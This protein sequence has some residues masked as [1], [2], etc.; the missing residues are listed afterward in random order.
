MQKMI[1]QLQNTSI[2]AGLSEAEIT[3]ALA[4]LTAKTDEY[5][6]GQCMLY[7]GTRVQSLGLLLTG[8]ALVVQEDFWGNCNLMTRLLPGQLFAESFACAAHATATVSVFA[9]AACQVLWIPIAQFLAP[10]SSACTY[11]NRMIQ[12]LLSAVAE[13]NLSIQQKLT[14]MGQ[15][16][17]RSKLLSYLSAQAQAQGSATFDIPLSRQQLADYLCV[18]RSAMSAALCR[19]RDE[20]V[21]HFS[22]NH[23]VLLTACASSDAGSPFANSALRQMGVKIDETTINKITDVK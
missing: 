15:R 10:C 2:F 17:T 6:K 22:K 1:I 23:F 20:G 13:K 8:S 16:T 19:L 9:D 14:H 11:H 7:A 3:A 18:E 21:L 4:C 12:N 5:Q